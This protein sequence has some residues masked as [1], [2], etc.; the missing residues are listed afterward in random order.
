MAA[1]VDARSF[2]GQTQYS[3]SGES[4]QEV[5]EAIDQILRNYHPDGYGTSFTPIRESGGKFRAYGRRN[6]SAD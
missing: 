1:E 3:I 4:Q 5:Q 6:N 2:A